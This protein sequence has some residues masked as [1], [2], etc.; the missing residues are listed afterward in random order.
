[1]NNQAYNQG[2][3]LKLDNMLG[4]IPKGKPIMYGGIL[5]FVLA[6]LLPHGSTSASH[7]AFS[8]ISNFLSSI[9]FGHLVLFQLNGNVTTQP[10]T[11]IPTTTTANTTTTQ[12][13]TSTAN[14][15]TTT[16]P[17]TTVN[18]TTTTANITSNSTTPIPTTTIPQIT[19]LTA[20]LVNFPKRLPVGRVSDITVAVNGGTPPYT[21]Q[22]YEVS[23]KNE[24]TSPAANCINNSNTTSVCQFKPTERGPYYI[25]VHV[26]DAANQTFT[27]DPTVLVGVYAN[28]SVLYGSGSV[29]FFG[30][31]SGAVD[32]TYN[33]LWLVNG[34]QAN[35]KPTCTYSV[36]DNKNSTGK[37]T[38]I[39][40]TGSS[41]KCNTSGTLNFTDG[42]YNVTFYAADAT[43]S[44]DNDSATT[45]VVADW[46]SGTFSS[47]TISLD[48][49]VVLTV[50][51]L[52]TGYC[53][54]SQYDAD[55]YDVAN[56]LECGTNDTP[57]G[58]N[59]YTFYTYLYK[60]SSSSACDPSGSAVAS[61]QVNVSS[62]LT[63]GGYKFNKQTSFTVTPTSN[64]VYC[65]EVNYDTK[66][67]GAVATPI[68]E[69]PAYATIT[70]TPALIST[71]FAN[72]TS[73]S[74]G[75]KVKLWNITTGGTGSNVYKYIL[76]NSAGVSNGI[77]PNANVF[78]FNTPGNYI[79]TL[80]VNDLS[81]ETASSNVIINVKPKLSILLIPGLT[82]MSADQG[83]QLTNTVTGGTPPYAF[84]YTVTPS[85]SSISGS[86]IFTAGPGTYN[87]V[88]KV[89]DHNG[90]TATSSNIITVT[91]TLK[92]VLTA[93]RT[94]IVSNDKVYFT[95]VTTGGTGS[96]VY[97]YTLNNSAGVTENG[98][99]F[100]FADP[101][102]Y[103]VTEHVTDLTGELNQ[104]SVII[105][106][107]ETLQVN[108]SSI[109]CP[110]GEVAKA[111]CAIPTFSRDQVI[112]ITDSGAFG[113]I[114]PY[115]YQWL[116]K[117][118]GAH[119]VFT[120]A[121]DCGAGNNPSV[122]HVTPCI[123]TTTSSSKLGQYDFILSVIDGESPPG[124]VS[125]SAQI[126]NL[127]TSLVITNFNANRTLI[128][129][130]QSVSFTNTTSGG[131]GADVW[132][133]TV[134]NSAGVTHTGN[135]F[136]F[137]N[138][139]KYLVT[140][141]VN[142][143]SGETASSNVI[144]T[145]TP[146]LITTIH[147]N[148]TL[149]S[150][151]QK[152]KFWN[153]TT[154]GTGSD[155]NTYTVNSAS[156]VTITGNVITFNNQ[157]SFLVTLTTT[158]I[159][160]EVSTSNITITVTPPLTTNINANITF[161][162]ADQ[163]VKFSGS[164]TGGT[165]SN[166]YLYTVN[167]T[168]GVT[169]N[170]NVFTFNTPGKFLVTLTTTDLTDEVAS[171]N[172][173]I[174]VT[175]P[176]VTTLVANR[177]LVSPDQSV[178]F[179]NITTGGT[180]SNV[181][182]YSANCD[183]TGGAYKQSGN[184]F[185]F[186]RQGRCTVTLT[187][188]DLSGE[189]SSNSVTIT[190][191]PP[192][193]TVLNPN[194]TL[195]S[196]GQWVSFANTTTGGTGSNT[197]TYSACEGAVQN[198]T[199]G[200]VWQ[201]NTAGT[202]KVTLHVSDLTGETNQSNA[203]ITV[204]PALK[205]NLYS[206]WT[207]ISADQSVKFWN[208]TS[209]GTGSNTFSWSVNSLTGVT[210]TGNVI[211]FT[212]PG[213]Y[214]VTVHV[215]D[216][217]GEVNQSS[218]IITVT[219]TVTTKLIA[220]RTLISVGQW[221]SFTNTTSGGTGSNSYSYTALCDGAV[222]NETNGNVWQFNDAVTCKVIL[223]V[224]DLTGETNSSN[225][226][227][228]VTPPIKIWLNANRTY[229]SADQSVK[230]WNTTTGGTGSNT[231]S[232]S[233]NSLTGVTITGNVITFTTPGSYNVTIHVK[234]ISGETNQSS[235]I[236][237]VTP[238]VTL[239][240]TA[241]RTYISADQSVKLSN[242]TTGG[243]GSNVWTYTLN[244]SKGVSQ[245]GNV[246]TFGNA[247]NY[248]I[249]LTVNDLSGETASNSVIIDVTPPLKFTSFNANTVLISANQSV[250]FTNTTSGGTG[251][252]VYTYNAVCKNVDGHILGY[253]PIIGNAG[254]F[255]I[256]GTCT[257]T[258]HVTDLTNETNSTYIKIKV[259]PQLGIG[260]VANWT[261]ISADQSVKFTNTTI[262][263][264]G[265]DIY[266]LTFNNT[267][268]VTH[269]T[270]GIYTFSDAGNYL[271]TISVTDISGEFASNSVVIHVTPKLNI[272][273]TVNRSLISVDQLVKLTNI[274]TGGTGSNSYW[275]SA[276]CYRNDVQVGEEYTISNNIINLTEIGTC[277][278][279][280]YVSDLT[281]EKANATANVIV[282]PP[283]K[284][285]T[286]TANQILISVNQ[287]VSFANTTS[288][289]TGSNAFTYNAVCKNVDGT[290]LGSIPI[291]GNQGTFT[292]V[293]ICKVTLNVSDLT[294]E[295]N[296]SNVTITVTPPLNTLL[297][298]NVTY[299]SAD[300]KV[301]FSNTT[302]GGTGSNAY[303][304][305]FNNTAGVTHGSDGIYSFSDAG[306]YLA[307]LNVTDISGEVASNSVI[308]DVT[309]PLN[310]SLIPNRTLISLG[311][312]VKLTNITTGG[313]GSNSYW[314]S[315]YCYRGDVQVGKE[316]TISNN[317]IN[318]TETGTC[319]IKEYVSDL[320]GEKANATA[321]ITVTP[322]LITTLTANTTFISA[323]QKVHLT[324]IT[325][326]GTGSNVYTLT[327]NNTE[328][329]THGTDGIYMFADAGNY[330]ATLNVTD[331]SGEFATSNVVIQVTPP[332]ITTIYANTVLISA[333]QNVQIWN[334]TTGGTG[335][336]V[337]TTTINNTAG[338][339]QT[340]NVFTFGTPGN[341]IITV[342]ATDLSG[343]KSSGS[344]KI[345]VTDTLY[346]LLLENKHKVV[347]HKPVTL[348][349]ITKGGTGGNV[350]NYT[351]NKTAGVNFKGNQVS[352]NDTGQYNI[353]IHVKD[354]SGET[355]Q[356]SNII[357]VDEPLVI[358]E[359]L[360]ATPLLSADQVLNVSSEGAV[361]DS[362]VPPYT[363]LWYV[364]TPTNP[365][366]MS[367]TGIC[368]MPTSL[369]CI[370]QTNTL[371]TPGQ[372][373]FVLQVTDSEIPKQV[374][375]T[376][377]L[378]ITITPPLVV[379][380]F[381]ATPSV[382]NTG[383]TVTLT[384]TTSGG[385]GE[386]AYNYSTVCRNGE[387]VVTG[388]YTL[389]SNGTFTFTK[390]ET[391]I[392]TLNV[393]D[394]TGENANAT[395]TVTVSSNIMLKLFAN[396]TYISADQSV[397]L[398]NVT[399]NSTGGN[400]YSYTIN[401]LSTFPGVSEGTGPSA[402][403]FTFSNP[404]S[405][406]ITLHVT[407]SVGSTNQSSVIIDVTPALETKVIASQIL[408]SPDQAVTVTNVTTGGTGSNVYSPYAV[409]CGD[410]EGLGYTHND[411]GTYTFNQN[412]TCTISLTV[413]DLS[414]EVA[415]NSTSVK[416][417]NGLGT[418]L[419]P[420]RTLI[421]LGQNVS[422]TNVTEG[423]TGGNVYN[424]SVR[425]YDDGELVGYYYVIINNK[426]NLNEIGTC[427]IKLNVKDISGE[428]ANSTAVVT[429]TPPLEVTSFTN[430]S[431]ASISA[432]Q[433][434]SFTNTTS[435]GTGSNSYSYTVVCRNE[436]EVID[437]GYN[438][439]DDGTISF[440]Q[441][442]E[443]CVV[444]LNVVDASGEVA[445][446]TTTV[447]VT[448]GLQVTLTNTT[449]TNIS[450]EQ[451][452]AFSNET[453]GG[454]GSNVYTYFVNDEPVIANDNGTLSFPTPGSY[455]VTLGVKDKSGEIANS[456]GVTVNVSGSL[457]TKLVANR[458]FISADQ[459]VSFKNTTSGG[460]GDNTFYYTSSPEECASPTEQNSS[461]FTFNEAGDCKVILHV[462][463]I[464][465]ETNQ[466][467][468]T[469]DVTPPLV[470][471]LTNT[472][473]TNISADQS[474]SFSNE[475]SGGTG[476]NIWTYVVK[477]EDL[478]FNVNENNSVTFTTPGTCTVQLN[479]TDASGEQASS[480]TVTVD[481]TPRLTTTL[482]P[483]SAT[484]ETG[485]TVNFT[486][487]TV[488]GTGSNVYSYGISCG[489][490]D[491]SHSISGNDVTFTGI[492]TCDVTL[493]VTDISGE[494]ANSTSVITVVTPPQIT[495]AA[496]T[497]LI[498]AGQLVDFTNVTTGGVP[499]YGPYAYTVNS[500]LPEQVPGSG[501]SFAFGVPGNYLF[502]ENVVDSVGG[503]ATSNPVVIQVN[504]RL[505][506]QTPTPSNI[507]VDQ[508][509]FE[510]I[511]DSAT[512]GTQPYDFVF[513]VTNE[514]NGNV[515]YTYST[516]GVTAGENIAFTYNTLN[517]PI[518]SDELGNLNINLKVTDAV[519]TVVTSTNVAGIVA[520][521]MLNSNVTASDPTPVVGQPIDLTADIA[522]G[523]YIYT[524]D[525][526]VTNSSG[527]VIGTGKT[528]STGLDVTFGFTPGTD[529][530]GT[531]SVDVLV[532]DN[533][534]TPT[535]EILRGSITVSNSSST[536]TNSTVTSPANVTTI[537]NNNGSN[538]NN[539]GSP[540]SGNPGSG[541]SGGTGASGSGPGGGGNFVPTVLNTTKGSTSCSTIYNFSQ[542]NSET[543]NIFNSTFKVTEN[544]ITP[545]TA[546]ITVNT[547]EYVLGVNETQSIG[548][549]NGV[550]YNITMLNLSYI[551]KIDT[552]TVSIC[553]THQG[554]TPLTKP[555]TTVVTTV[556]ATTVQTTTVAPKNPNTIT[557]QPT[558][559]QIFNTT[560]L[561]TTTILALM[562][563]ILAIL[564]A[565]TFGLVRGKH[566]KKR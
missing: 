148:W 226:T 63:S 293:G 35:G 484:V 422:L 355:N 30:N 184:I 178:S 523:Y 128:S 218:I 256:S 65:A 499:P 57:T 223:H 326:G 294:G 310:I 305:T 444:T 185:N 552:I 230:F 289:G 43:N 257:V 38:L 333:D 114:P 338:V 239:N 517:V 390:P 420:N 541:N 193:K 67:W 434:V 332:L 357:I 529:A 397:L 527:I 563:I 488:G 9:S 469:I 125:E 229:I 471:S 376:A 313:T 450:A 557:V 477:C 539:T 190:V 62:T 108:Q 446:A 198:E 350:Y 297:T 173:V 372:Y 242:V 269:G 1:M 142:D 358:N 123:F 40:T 283:L 288:G 179:T 315:A 70:V 147:A 296:S 13:T 265:N 209:G 534:T 302:I 550:S 266:T 220:N 236:I 3:K 175:P 172:V 438:I 405:Y 312:L 167:N 205:I 501:N 536:V 132:T 365:V 267:A 274:T 409:N 39:L 496:N 240:L 549:I 351:I 22:W 72:Q 410:V 485:Q 329:V 532:T 291:T 262:G 380:S 442:P 95:N 45:Q 187:V 373:S 561:S 449:T 5:L 119:S 248:L 84:S 509:E 547:A 306:N 463:D 391:C 498:D 503:M 227:I 512:G 44:S 115:T 457:Q 260:L 377:P 36:A 282:T 474:V 362:G 478:E 537:T 467:N 518:L 58:F 394:L 521:P 519:N 166:V 548:T 221:V 458:T 131:T 80:T 411:N 388:G 177:T 26:T 207:Y 253:V 272:T 51:W 421:S 99:V 335:S 398:W 413:T 268:G 359:S 271:A 98:N 28:V 17:T 404:G 464:S 415:T 564:A 15:T 475:T 430:S 440:T 493:Y 500:P 356:S 189:T 301:Q 393:T 483:T 486:N 414:G 363:Y 540:G 515:I 48:Q 126:L 152:V 544:F 117:M 428:K 468:V 406:N 4:V 136:T 328:G 399:T 88:I 42:T 566:H 59:P 466:S 369:D 121:V 433:S 327:F 27:I 18:I 378:F 337:Y 366:Y 90:N 181:Y 81:G 562:A 473:T 353:T 494:K 249:T 168:S 285:T 19:N 526:T 252:N 104:S 286:F 423:G 275:Y 235:K 200:N 216:V 436:D 54:S 77:G 68:T 96:N 514:T 103:N 300:Q 31:A 319:Y 130:D 447:D 160:G 47:N 91:P 53:G 231:F 465:G 555:V 211:T 138:A 342:N 195:I 384:N 370:F 546:G 324:N 323:D 225:V 472:T 400:V 325:T 101:G 247:G 20:S 34:T 528:K 32:N 385:T 161:I 201:F 331:I 111:E 129:G 255:S 554:Q 144:I 135:K 452:V 140:L 535:S 360:T 426:V 246:F 339:S 92:I 21:Y 213:S 417:T 403:V 24:S 76:N 445:N 278:I 322:P 6:M 545:T 558:I 237:T 396:V 462:S 146:P 371:T 214:N 192:L 261:Y 124:T 29:E 368:A 401:G 435:G 490:T 531:D 317:T 259:T 516:T 258:I 542:D 565:I 180:G 233:V 489:D 382:V 112:N 118:P 379:T 510:T 451:S 82:Y 343:E 174:T 159:S 150:A 330:L 157:G 78:T 212:T 407:D 83:T 176:L 424:Y 437:G 273:L 507:I 453:T 280:E 506:V 210:I 336:N 334:I 441:G 127:N 346:I 156:G 87:V 364:A 11:S 163:K 120:D 164:S 8:G 243:T 281:G 14:T 75:N 560:E 122:N 2:Y 481:V 511:S 349:N 298:A 303:S 137:N 106:V 311:Q 244:N 153:T 254:T 219:P 133:Y 55:N 196:V 520:H 165:G 228:T 224:T 553:G 386:N 94:A 287:T 263:G 217:S 454:T 290:V 361:G 408:V 543:L 480:G 375:N 443:T 183:D 387:E 50:A 504:P 522:G 56:A 170:G 25:G 85:G 155:V 107:N 295:T 348:T 508:G 318:L 491:G 279:K 525:L 10:T 60:S 276:Y 109:Q 402:N 158:D 171:A 479:V 251:S 12:P 245:T 202:C 412:E 427:Y 149:I 139:G 182:T 52:P 151:D 97:S 470:V 461:I 49:S 495:L 234:D 395:T 79:I 354:I 16:Q 538:D 191:T 33:M 250:S 241:N 497:T 492:Q 23:P 66:S 476:D 367:N 199:N 102:R 206:N 482:L 432:D 316:Y 116:E 7:S 352:F 321:I 347:Q 46:P 64:A 431:T 320:T 134:N 505:N 556:P 69:A 292:I 448:P 277:Y 487:D 345:Q 374:T 425:C 416:V 284:I 308:I 455:S 203:T 429:V 307:T 194:R 113:G 456:T 186:T 222:Q 162:S 533:A 439:N 232:W 145:V 37:S 41:Y 215:K 74:P 383:Q 71:L 524:Y 344:I 314:Y 299:I 559:G 93:N 392:I 381:S 341:Y 264:T 143:I 169:Q 459:N 502:T 188:T 419:I 460:T 551:P 61:T 86:G 154:G 418:V 141:T 270:D 73:I 197:F 204:T 530:L 238:P 389:N 513:T 208:V 89:T 309:P 105:T 340:G 100:T 110:P 304:L